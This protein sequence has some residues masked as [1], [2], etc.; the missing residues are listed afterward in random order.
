VAAHPGVIATPQTQ[1]ARARGRIAF[2]DNLRVLVIVLVVLIHL[3]I[4]YGWLS[5]ET[6]VRAEP[7]DLLALALAW[8]VTVTQVPLM[9]LMFFISGFLTPGARE[10]RGSGPFVRER[11]LRLGVPLL[12]YDLLINPLVLYT[13]L[14]VAGEPGAFLA[15]YPSL[16]VGIGTGPTWYLTNLLL[17][18]VL[19]LLLRSR[20]EAAPRLPAPTAGRLLLVAL[21]VTALTF[22]IRLAIPA[23]WMN[24]LNL[25]V[26]HWPLYGA[27]FAAGGLA[28]R[29]GW[30]QQ[31]GQRS[32][33]PWLGAAAL[34][35][36]L[37]WPALASGA[38]GRLLGGL[39]PGAALFALWEALLT[40]CAGV[41][42]LA[43]FGRRF[44]T[45][46]DFSQALAANAYGVYLLHVPV[47]VAV[48]LLLRPLAL[49]SLPLLLL[50]T[51]IA[52]P[53]CF[54]VAALARRLPFAHRVL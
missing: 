36:L 41:G 34:L 18:T 3:A 16:L 9:A 30:L 42:L 38:Y 52:L 22:L 1:S 33:W 45:Q 31:V 50:A 23:G 7:S 12:I 2:L 5:G 46:S 19:Y 48:A 25:R 20:V 43:L 4:Q 14:L 24:P 47:I 54:L 15:T 51:A 11:L 40:L 26:A 28:F 10:R 44:V 37:A 53:A 29:G 39:A 13:G 49:P 6:V 17:F 32:P 35:A 27:A 21:G 8:F